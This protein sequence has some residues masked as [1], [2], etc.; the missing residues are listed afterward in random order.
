MT[1]PFVIDC[2]TSPSTAALRAAGV[3]GV[4][5]YLSREDLPK[6]IKPAEY[7]RLT[8]DGFTVVLN[9]EFD[10]FDWLT[11]DGKAHGESAV[12]QA[13]ALNHPVGLPIPGSA[14]FD[15]TRR[16]WEQAGR[17]Y[18]TAY[19]DAI[20]IGGYRPGVYGSWDVLQ[21]CRDEL[22]YD[23]FWQSMSTSW[24]QNRNGGLF[25]GVHLVQERTLTIGGVECDYNEINNPNYG[26]TMSQPVN[27]WEQPV[28][29]WANKGRVGTRRDWVLGDLENLRDYLVMSLGSS[30][31][32]PA[33]DSP[34]GMLVKYLQSPPTA[35]TDGGLTDADRTAIQELTVALNAVREL[36]K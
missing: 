22:G 17:A 34:L 25:P 2:T 3:V 13:K 26:G 10:T 32:R 36:F 24:S 16:Q 31:M 8:N 4:C 35:P 11:A 14:D 29:Y 23:W 33:D 30:L 15:M 21:W 12:R 28:Q 27:E 6:V 5:R 18:A 20:R 1:V 9:W 7:N 19:R